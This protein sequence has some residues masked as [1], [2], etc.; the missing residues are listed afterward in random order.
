MCRRMSPG[1]WC[2]VDLG[3][4]CNGGSS[5]YENTCVC[6]YKH[7]ISALQCVPAPSGQPEYSR[8]VDTTNPE[9]ISNWQQLE[10]CPVSS[11]LCRLPDCF[12]SRSGLE[13]PGGLLASD[14]PQMILLTFDGPVTDQAFA[15]YKSL[16]SGKYR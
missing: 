3:I 5:C 6:P 15:A 13:I 7:V 8:K 2:D 16:L 9:L 11:N 12:C 4:I 14:V 10:D 1:S